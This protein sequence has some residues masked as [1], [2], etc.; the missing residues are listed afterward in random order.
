MGRP[1]VT[2]LLLAIAGLPAPAATIR[3]LALEKRTGY[4]LSR[5]IVTLEPIPLAGQQV[6]TLRTGVN[7]QYFFGQV[8]P[9]AY[10]L[11]AT[12]RG[13]MPIQYGQRRWDAAGTPIVITSDDVVSLNLPMMRY[14]AIAGTVRDSNEVGIPD[15]D[16]A[17]Y[18][19]TQPPRFVARGKSDERGV[20]RIA[21]LE[22]GTYL[23]RTIG[24]NDEELSY[25]PTFSQ[26]TLRVEE[27][28]P[29]V[30]YAEE[31][32]VDGDVRPLQGKLYDLTGYVPLPAPP[33]FMVTVT[34]ASDLGR[35]ISTG[36][37]FHF[38]ALAPGH[39]E[40]Y[41]EAR[42]NPPGVRA[43]GGYTELLIERNI[44]NLALPMTETRESQFVLEGAGANVSTTALVRRKDYAGV[45]TAQVLMLNALTSVLLFPGR[46]EIQVTAPPGFYVSH[47]GGP[48]NTNARPEGWNEFQ[49]VSASRSVV[50]L[51]S[52]P[53]AVHGSVRSAN[54]AAGGAPV[55]LEAWDPITRSRVM[56][57]R[58][59]R[60]DMAGNYR[61]DGLA[62]G[63]YRVISTYDYAAPSEQVFEFAPVTAIRV[64][65]ST[66]PKVDL[67][68]WG[69]P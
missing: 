58:E 5:A 44:S 7:G 35:I 13:F 21:G 22:P 42:E 17:A 28:R 34:L 63:D 64:E 27:A 3:G 20:F 8:P 65:K 66:D 10:L 59:T 38:P 53:G 24:N 57:L 50:T 23:V 45:G 29:L 32:T 43:L 56:D 6:R 51:S 54:A 15:Q 48:R 1:F 68:L 31:D 30:V 39:Y 40:L 33:N 36:P 12:R 67:A 60:S 62:P 49:V 19:N 9:G 47:F 16:V 11:K 69:N 46:W 52:G 4:G 41:A 18:S 55:F 26:Q 2:L 61:F 14:G 25:L 37:A